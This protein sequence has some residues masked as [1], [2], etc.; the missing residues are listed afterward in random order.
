VSVG[1]PRCPLFPPHATLGAADRSKDR[2]PVGGG[3]S[4]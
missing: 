4:A 3:L 2:I 1:H